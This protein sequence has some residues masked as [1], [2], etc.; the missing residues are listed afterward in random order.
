MIYARV[1]GKQAARNVPLSSTPQ[2]PTCVCFICPFVPWFRM[3]VRG[4]R[5][6]T[7]ITA[8]LSVLL[9]HFDLSVLRVIFQHAERFHRRR[10]ETDFLRLLLCHKSSL[11]RSIVESSTF[12]TQFYRFSYFYRFNGPLA[13]ESFRRNVHEENL[14]SIHF[15]FTAKISRP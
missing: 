4:R 8:F 6:S 3:V 9:K 5:N 2:F 13:N 15:S 7:R 1:P 10:F 11:K 14:P 12:L